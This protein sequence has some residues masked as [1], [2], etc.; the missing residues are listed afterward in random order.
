MNVAIPFLK[1]Q[2]IEIVG[3][4]KVTDGR[5]SLQDTRLSSNSRTMDLKKIDSIM[6]YI[7]PLDFSINIFNNKDAKLHVRNVA[8]KNN[9]IIAEGIIIVPKD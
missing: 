9:I 6:S 5:I 7:N 8:I 4:L 2:K 1:T 3:D